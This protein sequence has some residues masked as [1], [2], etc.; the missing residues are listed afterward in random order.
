MQEGELPASHGICTGCE[1]L[2]FPEHVAKKAE[3]ADSGQAFADDFE[4]VHGHAGQGPR[5]IY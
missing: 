3:V 5:N 4:R 2:Y 1:E